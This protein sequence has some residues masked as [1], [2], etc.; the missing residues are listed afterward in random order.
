MEVL[1]HVFQPN[2]LKA[3]LITGILVF[4]SIAIVW[5]LIRYNKK[6]LSY[7]A[8]KRRGMIN[9]V[10]GTVFLL[11]F[12]TAILNFWNSLKFK[13]IK[14][15]SSKIEMPSGTVQFK[16]IQKAYIFVDRPMTISTPPPD[17]LM[18]YDRLLIIEEFDKTSHA[19]ADENYP[20]EDILEKMKEIT[21]K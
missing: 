20:I 13:P 16:N 5:W 12:S 9:I 10:L 3:T 7:D 2:K 6:E 14:L 8:K 21:K 4:L 18:N 15:Y 19:L 17:S 1:I 11:T